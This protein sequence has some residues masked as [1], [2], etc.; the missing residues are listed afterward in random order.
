MTINFSP[1]PRSR[2]SSWAYIHSFPIDCSS[3]RQ[4]AFKTLEQEQDFSARVGS[5]LGTATFYTEANVCSPG[6]L[7]VIQLPANTHSKR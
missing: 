3:Y 1:I 7:P 6:S 2:M 4:R 5:P